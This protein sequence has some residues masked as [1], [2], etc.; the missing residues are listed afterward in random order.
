M[1]INRRVK[2]GLRSRGKRHEGVGKENK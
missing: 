1:L 2:K